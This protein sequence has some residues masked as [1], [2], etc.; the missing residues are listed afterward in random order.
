MKE[1]VYVGMTMKSLDYFSYGIP[2]INNINGDIKKIIDKEKV[3]VNISKRNVKECVDDIINMKESEYLSM[4]N[5][6][7]QTH[8]KYFSIE[9]FENAL[10]TL[11]VR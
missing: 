8:A 3:G 7:K 4:R 10:S 6:V 5:N 1:S 2:I 11:I 9:K